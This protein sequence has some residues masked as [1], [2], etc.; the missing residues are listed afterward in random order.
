MFRDELDIATAP[1]RHLHAYQHIGNAAERVATIDDALAL[2]RAR[3][4]LS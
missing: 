3:V 4:A 1:T 2:V